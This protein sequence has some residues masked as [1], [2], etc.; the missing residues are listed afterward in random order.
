MIA[1][2]TSG[3]MALDLT[4]V[5]TFGDGIAGPTLG[6]DTN[7][8]GVADDS[9]IFVAKE[10]LRDMVF[11][12]GDIEFGLTR[13]PQLTT[14]NAA[15]NDTTGLADGALSINA[16]EC[17][18]TAGP[19][20][21]GIGDPAMNVGAAVSTGNC[22]ADW[23]GNPFTLETPADL[24][25]AAC[26]PG[27][28]AIAPL[29]RWAPGSPTVCINYIGSCPG[30]SAN[31]GGGVIFTWP[32]SD[33]LVGF[34]G[35]G[36]PGGQDNRPGIL[37]WIDNRETNFDTSSTAGN[38]CNHA[39]TGDCELRATGPTPLG[40][41]LRAS[42]DYMVPI[43]AADTVGTCRPYTV[44]LLTD[45]VEVCQPNPANMDHPVNVAR[46]LFTTNGIPVYVVGLA[47]DP[48]SRSLL[49]NIATAGGTDAGA[50]GGDT[51]FF[52]DDPDT[53]SAGLSDIVRRSLLIEVCNDRDDNCNGL[54]DEGFVKF[55]NRPAGVTTQ[56][57]CADPG[58]TVCDGMDDNCNGRIDEGLLNACGGCGATPAEVC[59]GLDNDCDGL[60]DDGVCGGCVPELEVCDGLDNDC[61]GMTDE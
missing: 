33:V 15:C 53:L 59:D 44:M 4:G 10:A 16:N 46:D 49:N 9:R 54:I 29:R 8:D 12:F 51:A 47:I 40:G 38:W 37:R 50:A 30:N 39:T 13:F 45:G 23:D 36:W 26:R 1:F 5:P 22:G 34:S 43:R 60:I 42:R 35:F 25:P 24:Y 3:S 6:R 2:D 58:E 48:G 19:F 61:D 32:A 21:G 57:L 56:T 18:V 52:A 55:C 11:A 31:L 27:T 17:E 28:G 14:P 20:V 7:C 41:L